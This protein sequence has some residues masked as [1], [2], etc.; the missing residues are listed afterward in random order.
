MLSM[1]GALPAWRALEAH[2]A[3]L[4]EV[5]LRRLFAGDPGRAERMTFEGAG[6]TLDASKHLATPARSASCSTSRTRSTSVGLSVMLAIGPE[7]FR[8][9]LGGMHAMDDHFRSAPLDQTFDQWGVELG[10]VLATRIAAEIASADEPALVH[11]ASTNAL[12]RRY[13][14]SRGA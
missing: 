11:D 6:W 10:K 8:E 13:R 4:G 5:S 14:R 12:I 3:E 2:R 9:F 1:V 7:R